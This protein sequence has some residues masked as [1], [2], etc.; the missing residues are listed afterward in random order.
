MYIVKTNTN[1]QNKFGEACPWLSNEGPNSEGPDHFKQSLLS[2]YSFFACVFNQHGEAFSHLSCWICRWFLFVCLCQGWRLL[3]HAKLLKTL[4]NTQ[5]GSG[6]H[7][8]PPGRD[9]LESRGADPNLP[10]IIQHQCW[11]H[12]AYKNANVLILKLSW[13][14]YKAQLCASQKD[15]G[16]VW[17][18]PFVK[19]Y[20]DWRWKSN[21]VNDISA[22]VLQNWRQFSKK[23]NKRIIVYTNNIRNNKVAVIPWSSM[24]D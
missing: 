21:V 2:I 10:V 23:Q 5:K 15:N 13:H 12:V 8:H 16:R 24:I 18:P 22:V 6:E 19:L 14:G 11:L 7:V 9:R 4:L 1:V 3:S 20:H 17:G